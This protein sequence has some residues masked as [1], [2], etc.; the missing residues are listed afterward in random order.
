[1]LI[2]LLV[3]ASVAIPIAGAAANSPMHRVDV[4]RFAR[5]QMVHVT[6]SNGNRILR[7]LQ[8]TQRWRWM[9]MAA[10]LAIMPIAWSSGTFSVSPYFPLTGW[11]LGVAAGEMAFR[12]TGD[13]SLHPLGMRLVPLPLTVVWAICAAIS[14][15]LAFGVVARSYS[16]ETGIA[17]R[18]GAAATL[19]AV[20]TVQ[21]M[22][23]G[24]HRRALPAGPA[25]LVGAELATRSR[26][27]RSL[28]AAGAVVAL[29]TSTTGLPESI[30]GDVNVPGVL[31]FF[32]LPIVA[33]VKSADPW[34]V[35][36]SRKR[37]I[38][39]RSAVG[40]ALFGGALQVGMT[41]EPPPRDPPAIPAVV[42]GSSDQPFSYARVDPKARAWVLMG[43][44]RHIPV[45][46]A[47]TRFPGGHRRAPFAIS[48]DGRRIVYLDERTSRLVL[49]DLADSGGPLDL[50]GPLSGAAVPEVTLS[51]DGR[52]VSVGAEVIDTGTGSRTRLPGVGR[53]LGLGHDGVVATTGRR[54]LPGAPDTELLTL[55]L[56]GAV[57]TRVPFDP[58]LEALPTP[59]GR[60]L[61]VVTG[62]EVLTMDPGTGRVRGRVK[63]RLPGHYGRPEALSWA[64]DGRLLV[65]ID[66]MDAEEETCHLVDP[67]T[68]KTRP[69]DDMPE[70]VDGAVFGRF[71]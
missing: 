47:A 48:G 59:D 15:G 7:Y 62:D 60:G 24:L 2:G 29:W 31:I 6:A 49:R 64:E 44:G 12:G 40:V 58:T 32:G 10:G 42:A 4:E 5:R 37:R 14:C 45:D 21:A 35:C 43:K 25:D 19:A 23:S 34:Q 39:G 27:A 17:E 1:M 18:L 8:V 54:A 16:G 20:V 26:S 3:L 53:V 65:R 70:G 13:R 71:Q 41:V 55:D 51:R 69:V 9:G 11:L 56:H 52:Y 38:W 68:G 61:A 28:T 30:S 57:R 63:L 67:R 33:W 22:V 46:R 66:P 36:T 50:T